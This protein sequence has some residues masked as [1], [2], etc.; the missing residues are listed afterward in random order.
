MSKPLTIH[1]VAAS[2]PMLDD[3]AMADLAA[4][5]KANGLT[6]PITVKGSEIVDGRNRLK[7]CEIAGVEPA[8]AQWSAKKG[9]TIETWII[10]RNVHRRHLN[11]SQRATVAV[12]LAESL[13]ICNADGERAS[14]TDR[15]I[16]AATIMRVSPRTVEAAAA[17]VERGSKALQEAVKSG[18]VKASAAQQ[19]VTLPKSEQTALVR[20]GS[21]AVAAEAREQRGK[22]ARR[23]AAGGGSK[24]DQARARREAQ[25]AEAEDGGVGGKLVARRQDQWRKICGDVRSLSKTLHALSFPIIRAS[26]SIDEGLLALIIEAGKPIHRQDWTPQ[27]KRAAK[28]LASIAEK[29]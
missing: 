20:K 1:P 19:V 13:Q 5:I 23:A 21:D 4:D 10:S 15:R 24:S 25:A 22:K 9:V 2:F 16:A 29:L 7:A 11:E 6:D 14:Q 26:G 18:D 17:V 8:F 27:F 3:E 12:A 28:A